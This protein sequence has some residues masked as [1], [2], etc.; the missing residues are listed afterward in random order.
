ML[1]DTPSHAAWS[2]SRGGSSRL[3]PDPRIRVRQF[4][5]DIFV[6]VQDVA[7]RTWQNVTFSRY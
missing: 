6:E 7:S 2:E 3:H 5:R 1:M 4:G